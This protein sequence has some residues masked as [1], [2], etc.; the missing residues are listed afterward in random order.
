MFAKGWSAAAPWSLY[1]HPRL[2]ADVDPAIDLDP[3]PLAHA[4]HVLTRPGFEPQLAASIGPLQGPATGCHFFLTA[5][6]STRCGIG[7]SRGD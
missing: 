3:E 7:V 6:F 4:N 1:G 5:R 2:A